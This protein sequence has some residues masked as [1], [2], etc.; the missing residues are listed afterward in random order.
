[1]YLSTIS[2]TFKL[3]SNFFTPVIKQV[4]EN[5]LSKPQTSTYYF[6]CDMGKAVDEQ[7]PQLPSFVVGN[8]YGR[9]AQST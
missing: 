5:L 1:M 9:K 4:K 6:N 7:L 2:S 3:P 8:K